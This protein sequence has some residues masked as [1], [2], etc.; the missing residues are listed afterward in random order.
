M[1]KGEGAV[2]CVRC[3][4]RLWGS[5]PGRK[6][7]VHALPVPL[8]SKVRRCREW[9]IAAVEPGHGNSFAD[10]RSA[11]WA[12]AAHLYRRGAFPY[13]DYMPDYIDYLSVRMPT[14]IWEKNEAPPGGGPPKPMTV[15]A[16][17]NPNSEAATVGREG[18][19]QC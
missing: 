10:D 2:E 5:R 15:R 19:H 1:G 3:R 8:G 16:E 4:Q 6:Q 14:I 11:G 13:F 18:G 12:S 7:Q 17:A 9:Q